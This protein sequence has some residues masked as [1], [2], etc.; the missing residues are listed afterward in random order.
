MEP[1]GPV[2]IL[3]LKVYSVIDG[4]SRFSFYI[5]SPL[6]SWSTIR[7]ELARVEPRVDF[8][9]PESFRLMSRCFQL[10]ALAHSILAEQRPAA[11]Y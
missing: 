5:Q 9:R 4:I 10:V 1:T 2:V 3:D 7:R 11:A 6:R 8:F